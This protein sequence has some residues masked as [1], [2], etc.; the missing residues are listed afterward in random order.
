MT[1]SDASREKEFAELR[2]RPAA[3][4][5]FPRNAWYVAA[6][7]PELGREL[8]GRKLLGQQVVLFRA[9]DG[10]PVALSDW[11]PHRGFPLSKSKLIGDEIQCGYHGMRYDR[12][13]GCVH[14]PTQSVIPKGL[15]VRSYPVVEKWLWVWIW[16][17]DPEKADPALIPHTG[18][19]DKP[20]RHAF[21]FCYPMKGNFQLLH[22]NVMDITHLSFLHAGFGDNEDEK[23]ILTAES[24]IEADG[25]HVTRTWT[26]TNFIPDPP[27][28]KTFSLEP[29][30]AVDRTLIVDYFLPSLMVSVN[31][32]TSVGDSSRVVSEHVG[33]IPITPADHGESYHF[34]GISTSY[35]PPMSP[36]EETAF[37]RYVIHQDAVAIE[38]VQQYFEQAGTDFR[39]VT[40]RNDGVAMMGR[41]IVAEMVAAERAALNAAPVPA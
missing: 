39:E 23:E 7:G 38:A 28:A 12:T 20:Y 35:T 8:L 15:R 14:V 34:F 31:R 29:G 37:S 41:R 24:T 32:F 30:V 33:Q 1:C 19:E 4:M 17:G 13:G 27:V 40:L 9:E 22:D 3:D 2:N 10:T 18:H 11:C 5:P 26:M 16:M 36:A 21:Q 6:G 25:R